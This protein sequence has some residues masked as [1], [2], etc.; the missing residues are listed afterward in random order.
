MLSERY[1]KSLIETLYIISI[2]GLKDELI[3][4]ANNKDEDFIDENKVEW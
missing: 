2:S 1:Y 4:R 3:N